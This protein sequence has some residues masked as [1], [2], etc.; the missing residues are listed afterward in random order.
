MECRRSSVKGRQGRRAGQYVH[1]SKIGERNK[2]KRPGGPL[3]GKPTRPA[4]SAVLHVA[5][6]ADKEA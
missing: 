1:S 2:N 5:L 6:R 4:D 3:A